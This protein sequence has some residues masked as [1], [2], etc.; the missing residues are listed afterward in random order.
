MDAAPAWYEKI[1]VGPMI[2]FTV[3]ASIA[4]A[5]VQQIAWLAVCLVLVVLLWIA[6]VWILIK[7]FGGS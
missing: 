2:L 3:V 1:P 4:A 6:V 5:M 7:R